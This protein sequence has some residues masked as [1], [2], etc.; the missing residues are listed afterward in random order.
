M[1][2]T[3]IDSSL[4]TFFLNFPTNTESRGGVGNGSCKSLQAH[5]GLNL[6]VRKFSGTPQNIPFR[7]VV[8]TFSPIRVHS[9][10]TH[11]LK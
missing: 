8:L 5:V 11:R 10:V 1:V 9:D 4:G 6:L 3:V 2:Q 7:Q